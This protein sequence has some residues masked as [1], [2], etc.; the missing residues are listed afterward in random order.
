M[1]E[2]LLTE[3]RER[4]PGLLLRENEPLSAH[5]SFRIGGPADAMAFPASAEQTAA[6]S[7][8]LREKGE[9]PFVMTDS[10][11]LDKFSALFIPASWSV[12]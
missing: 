9:K 3:L 2:S 1:F 4:I 11:A 5:T 8:L 10:F 7:V 12:K 6:L